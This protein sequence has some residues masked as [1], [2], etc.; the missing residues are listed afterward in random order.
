LVLCGDVPDAEWYKAQ[1]AVGMDS[2]A[3][4][5]EYLRE[6]YTL[7]EGAS[8]KTG[9]LHSGTAR[10]D[11]SY[12][13]ELSR[14]TELSLA[15]SKEFRGKSTKYGTPSFPDLVCWCLATGGYVVSEDAFFGVSDD[16]IER[17][18]NFVDKVKVSSSGA[19]R[20]LVGRGAAGRNSVG[21][22]RAHPSG[23]STTVSRKRNT[24]TPGQVPTEL[25]RG[26]SYTD[27]CLTVENVMAEDMMHWV[28]E[29]ADPTG[30][31][32]RMYG[33]IAKGNKSFH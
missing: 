16:D 28:K 15:V 21:F 26:E 8:N 30:V 31:C 22:K 14:D 18:W 12:A 6:T 25:Q 27:P 2:A 13:S 9:V 32:L 17:V 7:V 23:S 33:N 19:C 1:N 11:P 10:L 3:H 5:S 29:S 20:A 24:D 4:V